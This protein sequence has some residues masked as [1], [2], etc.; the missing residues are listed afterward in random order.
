VSRKI[1]FLDRDGTLVVEP[2]DG[3]VD[4]FAKLELV[5]GVIPALLRFKAAGYELVVVSNQDGLG[6]PGFPRE[7]FDEV[8]G[9][10]RRV[11]ASQGIEFAEVLY[12]PHEAEERCD[13]RKPAVGLVRKYL[14][15]GLLD[16]PA[17]AVVGDRD[18]DLELARNLGLRGLKIGSDGFAGTWEGIAHALL[19]AP[20]TATVTR[21]TRE[22]E[23]AVAVDLDREADAQAKTGIGFF[24][25]MLEQLGKHGGFSLTV[26]C[27]GDLKVD[28]HHTV[29]DTALAL[30]QALRDAFGEK[31]GI[32]RYG[33]VLPMDEAAAEVAID[34]GG[35]AYFVF[36]GEFPREAV[37]GLPTELVPHFFRSL[38]DAL[39]AAI[40][41]RV[42]G[43]NTHHMVE[44]CFKGV[45]RALR[46]AKTRSGAE[47]PSTKGTL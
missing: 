40:Q 33:F 31:R 11:F 23:I 15:P 14:A 4:N 25:H 6:T 9:V 16:R 36:E 21:K 12:C 28:E 18:T 38:A 19:D 17:S 47:L 34:L 13:C 42:R 10:V 37:G 26:S 7:G 35:R 8:D 45:A 24:D 29:E 41:M 46:Q 39:G 44:A 32:Q 2:L 27:R 30:G 22:T 5:R 1:L 20:R 43:E 3:R